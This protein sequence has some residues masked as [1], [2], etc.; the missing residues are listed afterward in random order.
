MVNKVH[1]KRETE[2]DFKFTK[3][4]SSTTFHKTE[5]KLEKI[6]SLLDI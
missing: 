6:D 2:E 3:R 5:K 4:K 1:N